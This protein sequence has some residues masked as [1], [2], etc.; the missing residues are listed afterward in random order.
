MNIPVGQALPKKRFGLKK[1]DPPQDLQIDIRQLKEN[2]RNEYFPR[3]NMIKKYLNEFSNIS[4]SNMFLQ[5]YYDIDVLMW[6][7][8]VYQL[9]YAYDKG[10]PKVKR[11]IVECLKPLYFARAVTF[12]YLTW[13][14]AIKYAEDT[15]RAQAKAFASQKYYLLGLYQNK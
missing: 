4:I 5:D 13:R 15:I 12:N 2:L 8:D 9:L 14:Y 1:L 6:T 11:D 10:S 3:K 7:Q